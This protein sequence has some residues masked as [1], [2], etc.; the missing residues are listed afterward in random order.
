MSDVSHFIN[1]KRVEG[2]SESSGG[3][4]GAVFNPAT[5]EKV[6]RVAFAN[7]TEVDAAVQAAAKAFP[8]WAATPPLARARIM[9]KFL[10]LLAREHDALARVISEEHG[11]VFSDAQGEITRGVEV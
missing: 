1:G 10:E 9:F 7:A 6:R 8:G 2:R 4:S 5:G 3:R 11:K